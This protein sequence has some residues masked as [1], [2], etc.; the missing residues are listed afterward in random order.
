MPAP[1]CTFPSRA[2]SQDASIDDGCHLETERHDSPALGAG[3]TARPVTD[4]SD[5]RVREALDRMLALER[6]MLS[7]SREA[8]SVHQMLA[9]LPLV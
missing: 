1:Q 4:G 6:D 2:A 3:A 7:V 5:P 9:Q 8:A